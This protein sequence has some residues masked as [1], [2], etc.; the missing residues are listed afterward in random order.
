MAGV[1][2]GKA[3]VIDREISI[4]S[5]L[6]ALVPAWVDETEEEV[7]CYYESLSNFIPHNVRDWFEEHIY[8]KKYNVA[9][10][11]L[12]QSSRYSEALSLYEHFC[13]YFE[14]NSNNEGFS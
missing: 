11:F 9:E 6:S 1:H 14:T 12:S 2:T 13:N 3:P 5:D 7:F 8:S 10:P 4:D